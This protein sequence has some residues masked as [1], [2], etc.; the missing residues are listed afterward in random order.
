MKQYQIERSTLELINGD[1][2]VQE[3]D[4]VVNAAN[5]GLL[6]GGGVC[7]ALFRAAG[8]DALA[9]ACAALA[10]CPT[11]EARITPG[12]A[13]PARFVIHAVGPVYRRSD[14]QGA[15]ALLASAYRS[16][17]ALA[18]QQRLASI[19]FPSISTGIFGYPVGEA[20]EVAL[21]AVSVFLRGASSLR[22]VRFVL[23]D[24][25]SL[26]AYEQDVRFPPG[27]HYADRRRAD[28]RPRR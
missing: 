16:S 21:R 26:A 19:A 3:L 27:P 28:G 8:R 15:A 13:L 9:A 17:L 1:I 11:G 7:G 23:W 14:P 10:P 6:E 24:E 20:A 18:A 4:A 22:L 2:V 5:E 25:A 12:F